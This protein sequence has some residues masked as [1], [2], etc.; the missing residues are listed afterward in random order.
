MRRSFK[1]IA[2]IVLVAISV[3]A[4]Q[5]ITERTGLIIEGLLLGFLSFCFGCIVLV[6]LE[7]T[8]EYLSMNSKQ[9]EA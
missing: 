8:E 2:V 6:S 3:Y 7:A 1:I 4:T 5:K 9:K